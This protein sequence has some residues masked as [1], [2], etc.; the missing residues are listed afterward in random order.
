MQ[1]SMKCPKCGSQLEKG[2]LG[3]S[4]RTALP[5]TILKKGDFIGDR[6]IPFY[7]KNCGYI[8]LFSEKFLTSPRQ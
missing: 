6:I 5:F 3:Y 8:E 7:C 4:G 2:S 1:E